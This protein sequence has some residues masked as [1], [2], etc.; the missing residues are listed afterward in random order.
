VSFFRKSVGEAG[1]KAAAKFLKSQ[2]YRVIARN[3]ASGLGEIDIIC[4]HESKLVFV[5]VKTLSSDAA[6][7]PEIHVNV[8]K[9][10]QIEKATKAWL[11]ANGNPD[12]GYRFDVVSVV[13]PSKGEAKIRHMVDAFRPSWWCK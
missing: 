2:G 5:E 10:R 7:D 8:S 9:Q 3:Y 4:E 1:E 13:M 11:T 12:C 6:A